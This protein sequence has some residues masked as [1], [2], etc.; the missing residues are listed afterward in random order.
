MWLFGVF[1]LYL[2]LEGTRPSSFSKAARQAGEACDAAA[3]AR[4]VTNAIRRN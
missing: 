2:I 1:I 4:L 3:A